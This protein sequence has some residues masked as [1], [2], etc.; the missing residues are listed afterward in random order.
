MEYS[1][2]V[3]LL[4][5]MQY[6]IF[7]G[8]VGLARGKYQ[9]KAPSVSGNEAWE[10]LY[11]VQMNTLEQL[12]IFVPS[13]LLFG[14][15]VGGKWVLIPGLVFLVGRQLYAHEYVNAPDSRAP[16]MVLTFFANVI[17]VVGALVAVVLRLV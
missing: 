6:M 14:V 3:I 5:M 13:A 15:F 17:C 8:R 16:G 7:V 10:R 9:V 11:R 1:A 12:I 2:I 4:A